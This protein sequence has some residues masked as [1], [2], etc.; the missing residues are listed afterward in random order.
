MREEIRARL[1]S[2]IFAD[3]HFGAAARVARALPSGATG[4][5]AL[6]AAALLILDVARRAPGGDRA[7]V[8]AVA[9]AVGDVA[10]ELLERL[11]ALR[12]PAAALPASGA[13][14]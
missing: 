7:Y 4:E 13:A 12:S 9:A 11:E 2:A 10:G 14:R 5:D 6:L 3:R 8:E 1:Q